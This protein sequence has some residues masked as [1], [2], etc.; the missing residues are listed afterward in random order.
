[1]ASLSEILPSWLKLP[2]IEHEV[3]HYSARGST[4]LQRAWVQQAHRFA[5]KTEQARRARIGSRA[6]PVGLAMQCVCD[7]C[8]P[9]LRW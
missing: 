1:V 6:E 8:R 7:P 5:R 9:I 4:L 3:E 2:M